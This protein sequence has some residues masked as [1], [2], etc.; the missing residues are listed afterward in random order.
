MNFSAMIMANE[1]N[2]LKDFI[3]AEVTRRSVSSAS[4]ASVSA[5][6]VA[7]D[8]W[9]ESIRKNLAKILTTTG[10]EISAG[11]LITASKRN[12]LRDYAVS[13]YNTTVPVN[14]ST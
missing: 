9:W 1:V 10:A 8:A 14:T 2:T 3:A 5:G 6:T 12:K 11:E 7:D 13:A 4:I